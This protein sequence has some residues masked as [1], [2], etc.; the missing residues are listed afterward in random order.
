[1]LQAAAQYRETKASL[2]RAP[3]S[4]SLE[5]E[6]VP[7]TGLCSPSNSIL[8]VFVQPLHLSVSSASGGVGGVR[9]AIARQHEMILRAAYP[10]ADAGLRNELSEQ[11]VVLLDSLLSGYVAQLTS[12]RRAAQ[13]ERYDALEHEYTQ[14][15]SELLAPLREFTSVICVLACAQTIQSPF[16]DHLMR[17]KYHFVVS[18][19]EFDHH[20]KSQIKA[21]SNEIC[22]LFSQWSWVNISGSR[23]WQRNTATLTY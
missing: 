15:R 21:I 19:C 11:L 23:R 6:Y 12:L 18:K 17:I 16:T 14:K 5:P 10:Y 4:C 7:W 20:Q 3:E 2:Y 1:M 8:Y 13:Q 22:T 9:T